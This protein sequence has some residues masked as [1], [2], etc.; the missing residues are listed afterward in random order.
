MDT[1]NDINIIATYAFIYGGLPAQTLFLIIY[2]LGPWRIYRPTRAL[3]SKS[4]SFWLLMSQ[5]FFVLHLYGL[6]PLD[7]PAWMLVYRI[8]GDIFML[9]AIYYQ[10]YALIRERLEGR[11]DPL[12]PT[13]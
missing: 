8:V 2:W 10:L 5:S 12:L 11:S 6:R 4:F 9:A 7:W 1:L 13:R 3:M